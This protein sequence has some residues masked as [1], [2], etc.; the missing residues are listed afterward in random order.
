MADTHVA[1]RTSELPGKVLTNA[2]LLSF[3]ADQKGMDDR[4]AGLL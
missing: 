1:E 4:V 2:G 3:A